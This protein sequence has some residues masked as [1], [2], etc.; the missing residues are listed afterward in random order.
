MEQ[1]ISVYGQMDFNL[2]HDLVT[3]PTGGVFYK[4]KKKSLKVGYLT[5]SDENILLNASTTNR[6]GVVLQLL[7]NKIYETDL[8]PEELLTG[9]VEALLIFLRNTAFGSSYDVTLT[10]PQTQKRFN[11]SLQ[12]DELNIK[13]TE[14]KPNEEGVFVIKLPKSG[15]EVKIKP[16]SLGD[17]LDIEKMVDSYPTNR[18]APKVT[19]RLNKQILSI[20][21]NTDRGM[22]G[23]F[24]ETMP[25]MD[26]KFIRTFLND[27]EPRLDLQK[28]VTAPSGEKVIVAITFGVEFFRPFY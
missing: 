11:V 9:D 26:S 14:N 5:A 24:I 3:L 22:I 7:R 20:D 12:L 4:N 6:E 21:G 13:K 10:D 17:S 15:N 18:V 1:D 27:N 19:W 23:K 28:E 8:K 16:L 25:I 2:P